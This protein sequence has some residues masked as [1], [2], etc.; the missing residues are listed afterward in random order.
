MI[1]AAAALGAPSVSGVEVEA[2]GSDITVDIPAQEVDKFEEAE[3]P[4]KNQVKRF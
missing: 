2:A 3:T 4:K 1:D